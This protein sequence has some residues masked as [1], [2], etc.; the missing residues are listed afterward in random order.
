MKVAFGKIKITP[1][2]YLGIPLAGYTP[3]PKCTGV[4]DDLYAHGVLIED[5]ELGNIKRRVLLISLDLLKLSL[6]FTNYIK[7]KI[8]KKY[9]ISPGQVLI[10]ATHT[11]KGPDV[12]GEFDRPGGFAQIVFN[13]ING[14]HKNDLYLVWVAGQIVKLVGE[15]LQKLRPCK[16]AWAREPPV[17]SHLASNRRHAGQKPPDVG[18]IAFRSLED[19]HLIGFIMHFAAHGITL[20]RHTTKISADWIGFA[21]RRV[22]DL[23]RGEVQAAYFNGPS[24]DVSPG[25]PHWLVAPPTKPFA[26]KEERRVYYRHIMGY[27][28]TEGIGNAVGE[29][30]LRLAQSIPLEEYLPKMSLR[31]YVKTIWIPVKDFKYW[32]KHWFENSPLQFLKRYLLIPIAMTH[33]TPNFPGFALKRRGCMLNTYT[34]IQW[35]LIKAS[36]LDNTKSKDLSILTAPGELF[37]EIGWRLRSKCPTGVANTF[38]FQ[39]S[40]DWVSYLFPKQLYITSGGYEPYASLSPMCGHVYEQEMRKLFQEVTAGVNLYF[41]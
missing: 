32:S 19:D 13:I 12:T 37:E 10:H 23:T 18:V 8:Q 3:I 26:S 41:S 31:I 34:L 6:S 24:G 7:E 16:I 36:S 29:Q 27:R 33:E 5:E 25:V 2:H 21:V 14:H 11:H 39:N 17:Y 38:I 30:A 9:P 15:L 22:T 28:R 35:I 40:H 1:K 20:G 4:L